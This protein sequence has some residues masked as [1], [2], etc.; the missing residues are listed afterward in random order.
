MNQEDPARWLELAVEVPRE[1]EE[2]VADVLRQHVPGG[3]TIE[4]GAASV[5]I[6]SYLPAADDLPRLKRAVR[7]ALTTLAPSAR[8]RTRWLREEDWAHAWK[9]FFPVLRLSPRL[10]L[11]PTWRSY[12]ARRGEAVIRL[13]PGMAF[14]T[15]QHPTTLMCLCALEELVRPGMSVLDLG[16]GS[17]ILALAA[18]RLGAASVLALDTD[19]QAVEIARENARINGLEAVVRV[20]EG[21]LGE[22]Q[23]ATFDLLVANISASA[24][25]DLAVAMA[26][27]LK[28]GGVLIAGGFIEEGAAPVAAALT[29]TGLAVECTLS[30]GDWRTLIVGRQAKALFPPASRAAGR[31]ARR[32]RSSPSGGEAPSPGRSRPPPR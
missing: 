3:V 13:D 16:S 25:V 11:C 24:I 1:A 12:R 10:V 22:A 27:A 26:A 7:R 19:P 5:V 20:E 4:E 14:G 23:G 21:S 31:P 17:G 30:D 9:K 18:A 32:A 2:A 28:P 8:F 6:K 15:G 29:A